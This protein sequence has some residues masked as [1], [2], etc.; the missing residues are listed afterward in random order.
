[1][2]KAFEHFLNLKHSQSASLIAKYVDKLLRGEKGV[3]EQEVEARL[4]QVLSLLLLV[5]FVLLVLPGVVRPYL[6]LSNGA[7]DL[8]S[9]G[10]TF[11]RISPIATSASHIPLPPHMYLSYPTVLAGDDAVPIP[12]RQRHVRGLLQEEPGQAP[13]AR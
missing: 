13:A 1:M 10:I 12:A 3:T 8:R 7:Y 11:D 9:D 4:D 2:K 5:L 6:S